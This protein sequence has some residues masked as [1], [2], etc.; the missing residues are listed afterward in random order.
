[1]ILA[2]AK[3]LVWFALILSLAF[4]SWAIILAGRCAI[5][6]WRSK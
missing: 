1:V 4:G 6:Y 2:L 3:A 5:H